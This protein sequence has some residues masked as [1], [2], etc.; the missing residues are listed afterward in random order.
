MKWDPKLTPY[1]KTI[2]SKLAKDQNV[3]VKTIILLQENIDVSL[4][5]LGLGNGFL[6]MKPNT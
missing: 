3:S 5:D 2:N 1:A 6:N 4:Q